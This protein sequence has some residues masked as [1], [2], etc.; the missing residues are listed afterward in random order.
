MI[1]KILNKQ[2]NY[3]DNMN[4]KADKKILA[5][6]QRQSHRDWPDLKGALFE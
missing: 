6:K 5:D 4:I 3:L 2:Y 1:S